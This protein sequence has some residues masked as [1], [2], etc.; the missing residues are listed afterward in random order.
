MAKEQDLMESDHA[1]ILTGVFV[2]SKMFVFWSALSIEPGMFS[3]RG[4]KVDKI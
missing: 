2:K 1:N 4:L 3:C